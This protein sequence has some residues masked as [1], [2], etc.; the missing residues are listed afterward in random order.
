MEYICE[1]KERQE[2]P[3]IAIRTRTTVENI[4]MVVGQAFGALGGYMAQQGAQMA[5]MPYVAYH[6]MDMQ[7]LD[8]EVGFPLTAPVPGAGELKAGTIPAGTVITTMHKG[9]Y[10]DL[11]EAYEALNAYIQLKGLHP[12]G[13]VYEFYYN[14]PDEVKP[15]DL[16]T[17][18][19]FP[20]E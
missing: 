2:T 19:Q 6:N 5:G 20:L 4:P 7:D 10:T 3:T 12:T 18:I 14:A 9:A 8:M 11:G 16:L 13:V 17:E 15:E 1:T